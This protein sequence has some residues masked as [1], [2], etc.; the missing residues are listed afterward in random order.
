[1]DRAVCFATCAP[2]LEALLHEEARALR[3]AKLE[4]QVGGVRFEGDRA[5]LWRANLCLRTAVRVLRRVARFEARDADALYRGV[6]TVDWSAFVDP[7]GS[8]LVDAQVRESALDHS[9]FVEQRVKDGIVDQLRRRTGR[10]PSVERDEP[11]LRV[12]VH[13]FRDRVTLSLDASGESLHKRGWRRFQ[14]R[15]PLAETLA[16]AVILLS[17]W[18][19]R[20]PLLDPFAGSGTLLVEAALLAAG[21][22]PGLCRSR[23]G[24][25]SWRDHDAR[26]FTRLKEEVRAE[27]RA[28]PRLRIVG[29][30][31]DPECVAG[32][33][34][35][36]AS[37]G[38]GGVVE[39]ERADARAFAPRP[40]W[41][42]WIVTNPPYGQRVGADADL[43]S[44]YAA[45]GARLREACAGYRLALLSGDPAHAAEL[46][47]RAVRR[48]A[49]K[50]GALDCELLLT[51][52]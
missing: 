44:L 51:E 11:D 6:Q 18:D 15:A 3:L 35:N 1:M 8:L 17:G 16:A 30:D 21:V 5:A 24:F 27:R 25:E 50:N 7:A 20:A 45:F 13:V 10:R 46:G 49:L 33:L 43:S 42:A 32:A 12:H 38:V 19:R 14:G 39:V 4:R 48:I 28:T 34:E 37:A 31:L 47:L 2:G 9:R 29:G 23:F 26:A 22:A 41:N 40:G 52:L 36:A